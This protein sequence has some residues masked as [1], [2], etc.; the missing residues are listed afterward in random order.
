MAEPGVDREITVRFMYK[1]S[2][3]WS[4]VVGLIITAVQRV[5]KRC[6]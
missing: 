4:Q 6:K 5:G 3:G 2:A 1:G